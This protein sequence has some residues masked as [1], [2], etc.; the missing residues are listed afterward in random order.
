MFIDRSFTIPVTSSASSPRPCGRGWIGGWVAN[1][2]YQGI[3]VL[4]VG[5]Y[6]CL[7]D[8]DHFTRFQGT[9]QDIQEKEASTG[10]REVNE[11]L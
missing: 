2:A 1:F 5:I 10:V 11:N 6:C 8:V 7:L 3:V 4:H 9:L